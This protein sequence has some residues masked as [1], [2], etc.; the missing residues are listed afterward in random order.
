MT[1][2]VLLVDD[3]RLFVEMLSTVLVSRA[4]D[5]QVVGIA[6]S[7][8]D[9]VTM[10]AGCDPDVVLLDVRM[11]GVD[12]VHA[13]PLILEKCP[14]A[15]VVMLTTF[16]DDEYV[17]E[18]IANGAVGYLL[19]DMSPEKLFASIR[20]VY[21]GASS[22]S[23][24]V[25]RRLATGGD[26][27]VYPGIPSDAEIGKAAGE[28]AHRDIGILTCI[29]HGMTN[30]EISDELCLALQTVK[31]KVSHIYE[32]FGVHDRAKIAVIAKRLRTVRKSTGSG[33]G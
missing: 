25:F 6:T 23:P 8:S 5:F 2:K 7:G 9:A 11:P 17:H 27:D 1:I 21:A 18:A 10:V 32:T 13:V 31:N 33:L 26:T 16:D 24:Q 28:L 19:K 20:A 4:D 15:K 14:E 12:G 30:Q 22:V 29:E 3:Q